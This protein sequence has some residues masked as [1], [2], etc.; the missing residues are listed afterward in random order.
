[1]QMHD[2]YDLFFRVTK[3]KIFRKLKLEILGNP[4]VPVHT[5]VDTQRIH[6]KQPV[7]EK[8]KLM[9][10]RQYKTPST[11]QSVEKKIPVS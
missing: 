6:L 10:Q 5:V 7:R 4:S 1:M 2:G 9:L 3:D 8:Q 11:M